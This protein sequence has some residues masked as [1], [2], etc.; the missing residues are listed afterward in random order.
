MII[1]LINVI[2]NLILMLAIVIPIIIN[3]ANQ[4]QTD[5]FQ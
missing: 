3:K 5:D 4:L 2:F 1:D